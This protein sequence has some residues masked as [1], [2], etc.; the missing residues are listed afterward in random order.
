MPSCIF[1]KCG[2]WDVDKFLYK[3]LF[4]IYW[5]R[6]SPK[7]GGVYNILV[8]GWF[9]ARDDSPSGL[10]QDTTSRIDQ[11]G[12]NRSD[13]IHSISIYYT[14][15]YICSTLFLRKLRVIQLQNLKNPRIMVLVPELLTMV[16]VHLHQAFTNCIF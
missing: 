8:D 13:I 2:N 12:T 11:S 4:P 16:R 10:F 14:R 3:S 5:S 1:V 9:S 6:T 7:S 15:P